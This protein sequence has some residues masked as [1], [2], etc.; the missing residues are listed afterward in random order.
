MGGSGASNHLGQGDTISL[1]DDTS[2]FPG[3]GVDHDGDIGKLFGRDVQPLHDLEY[4]LAIGLIQNDACLVMTAWNTFAQ[5]QT[6][7]DTRR[8]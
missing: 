7:L 5:Q 1:C 3:V 6:E 4:G 2:G 8:H